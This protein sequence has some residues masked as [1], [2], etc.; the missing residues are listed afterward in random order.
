MP[1]ASVMMWINLGI[2]VCGWAYVLGSL[3]TK[4]RRNE[5]D[6]R[7]LSKTTRE[8]ERAVYQQIG[9]QEGKYDTAHT[10]LRQELTSVSEKVIRLEAVGGK[11]DFK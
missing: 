2:T 7:D 3:S 9:V 10:R 11:G 8:A 5:A 1:D 4:V 6:I